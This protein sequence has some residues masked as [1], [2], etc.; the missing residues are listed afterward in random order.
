[1][2]SSRGM[3]VTVGQVGLLGVDLLGEHLGSPAQSSE[4]KTVATDHRWALGR[5]AQAGQVYD[6]GQAPPCLGFTC[7]PS[8][9]DHVGNCRTGA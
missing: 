7:P 4:R 1:M 3:L 6:L 8:Y 2:A 9:H 5:W